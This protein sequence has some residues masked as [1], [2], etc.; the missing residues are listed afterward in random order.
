MGRNQ[1]EA[2]DRAVDELFNRYLDEAVRERDIGGSLEESEIRAS[3]ALAPDQVLGLVAIQAQ[4]WLESW[5]RLRAADGKLEKRVSTRLFGVGLALVGIVAAV[6]LAVSPSIEGD[7]GYVLFFAGFL[8][9]FV[10]CGALV[11]RNRA[12]TKLE[13]VK[14]RVACSMAR[15][16]FIDALR[17]QTV[18]SVR[19]AVNAEL[20]SCDTEIESVDERGLR[21]LIDPEREVPTTAQVD[22]NLLI[23][24]LSNGSIGLSGPRGAGKTTLI[25]SFAEG[26]SKPHDKARTGLVVSAP[27]K[28]DPKEFVLHLFSGLCERVLED[29]GLSDSTKRGVSRRV[30][31]ATR[32]RKWLGRAG[33]LGVIVGVAMLVVPNTRPMTAEDIAIL[34][35]FV[36][37]TA[38]YVWV[39]L[40]ATSNARTDFIKRFNRVFD[41]PQRED[42]NESP[43]MLAEE[44]LG[45]IRFQ[46]SISSGRGGSMKLPFGI[47]LTA[48]SSA[49]SSRTPWMLP[50]VVDE[51]RRF[52]EKLS[53]DDR[54]VV[55]GID[56]LDKMEDIDAA[57]EFLNNIKGVFGAK[58]CF[59]LVSVS[60]DAMSSFERRGLPFRDVFDSSFDSILRVDYLTLGESRDV[61][62]GR[63]T[64]LPVPFQC[65]CHTVAGGLP[66]DLIRVTRELLNQRRLTGR[67]SL[68]ELSMAMVSSELRSKVVAAL[69]VVRT[70]A[71]GA[72]A[73]PVLKQLTHLKERTSIVAERDSNP[74]SAFL[75][76]LKTGAIDLISSLGSMS[77]AAQ[78]SGPGSLNM[79]TAEVATFIYFAV[80]FAEVFSTRP[81]AMELWSGCDPDGH[82]VTDEIA[83]KVN[84][85]TSARQA[86]TL[87]P[88]IAWDAV[89]RVRCEP[90]LVRWP[91]SPPPAAPG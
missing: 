80:T 19:R 33:L 16:R 83:A 38:L 47:G 34:L 8:L 31:R 70:I 37:A 72:S 20:V 61:L 27:V 30:E 86:F 90:W 35:V 49:T 7:L 87:S 26:P 17:E 54:Y 22:L 6:L 45:Q 74:N 67:N 79:V 89:E 41:R 69:E 13:I 36:G 39:L 91:T 55:V 44:L 46:Q 29:Y 58:G 25:R 71:P 51:F 68:G 9:A 77:S 63:I 24:S 85:L 82:L 59:Y 50:E 65:L 84:G 1:L 11:L 75:D 4:G 53:K 12:E 28:Y 66:R 10:A 73:E 88:R 40:W 57:R 60:D 23:R 43:G 81:G 2:D 32:L 15:E 3:D 76:G 78:G 18:V 56:E 64:G 14:L 48:E 21:Q 62:E 52:A 42:A 5:E